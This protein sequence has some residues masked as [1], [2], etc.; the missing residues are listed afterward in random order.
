AVPV[1][2][3]SPRNPAVLS[4]ETAFETPELSDLAA[5]R[6]GSGQLLT[7]LTYFDPST[8]YVIPDSP[9]PDGR[10][11]P[12]RALL[13]TRWLPADWSAQGEDTP[14]EVLSYRARSTA[15]VAVAGKPDQA[16][17]V[18]TAVDESEPQVFTTLV[19]ST[20]RRKAQKMQTRTRGEIHQVDAVATRNGW[21]V[22]WIDERSNRPQ[23]Y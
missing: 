9:A 22:A 5:T 15:G 14:S 20:G 10:F 11:K 3:E 12:V 19:D 16:L 13:E 7:T 1:W 4:V 17:I 8:P 18:W 2:A 23:T 6:L 21:M